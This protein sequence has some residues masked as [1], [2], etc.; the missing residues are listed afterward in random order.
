[1]HSLGS[2]IDAA[3]NIK[4]ITGKN[5]L[6]IDSSSKFSDTDRLSISKAFKFSRIVLWDRVKED[7]PILERLFIKKPEQKRPPFPFSERRRG[8]YVQ[9]AKFVRKRKRI[10]V[11]SNG[12]E[13]SNFVSV[14]PISRIGEYAGAN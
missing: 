3:K 6:V 12:G 7:R 5:I 11:F 2:R 14:L 1:M 10:L 13:I 8:T 9:L 4:K